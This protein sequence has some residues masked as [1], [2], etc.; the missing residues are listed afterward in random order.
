MIPDSDS[1]GYAKT[2]LMMT[3]AIAHDITLKVR[4]VLEDSN[5]KEKDKLKLTHTQWQEYITF[6]WDD[7]I[8]ISALNQA[9]YKAKIYGL[10]LNKNGAFLQLINEKTLTQFKASM[11]KVHPL[12]DMSVKDSFGAKPPAPE[13]RPKVVELFPA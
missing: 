10:N 11:K 12:A 5:A 1:K 4:R 6:Y 13:K 9:I 3:R 7:E 2:S 8:W